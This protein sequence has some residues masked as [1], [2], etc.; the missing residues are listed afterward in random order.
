[1]ARCGHPIIPHYPLFLLL[2]PYTLL[3]A[4]A[5][6]YTRPSQVGLHRTRR[7]ILLAATNLAYAPLARN[8]LRTAARACLSERIEL[9]AADA[10]TRALLLADAAATSRYGDHCRGADN[11]VNNPPTITIVGP[12][13]NDGNGSS[14]SNGDQGNAGPEDA[15]RPQPPPPPTAATTEGLP[16][17]SSGFNRLTAVRARRILR[18]LRAGVDVLYSDVDI[19][20][21]RDPFTALPLLRA[22]AAAA[23][24]AGAA[25][26]AGE[27]GAA[28][29]SSSPDPSWDIAVAVDERPRGDARARTDAFP[30]DP[31]PALPVSLHSPV[32]PVACTGF[33]YVRSTP[34]SIDLMRRWWDATRTGEE[35]DQTA[36]NRLLHGHVHAAPSRASS[37][38]AAAVAAAA[39]SGVASPGA[40]SRGDGARGDGA[41][42]PEKPEK[43]QPSIPNANPNANSITDPNTYPNTYPNTDT[44]TDR[45]VRVRYLEE[46]VVVNG[47]TFFEQWWAQSDRMATV[48]AV[49]NNHIKGLDEKIR[50][51]RDQGLWL[52][53]GAG[54]VMG[55]G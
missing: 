45:K 8:F 46:D 39:L 35:Q 1:M 37:S 55:D 44:N 17:N 9:H 27:A 15:P 19:A 10:A 36:F 31:F 43:R 11:D 54:G 42:E 14:G 26:E 23:G 41:G 52:L 22:A 29:A 33:M 50:R 21:L 30:A 12:E 7:P 48:T 3:H 51:F 6:P 16:F 25:G 24:A 40:A 5:P 2:L 49:H 13:S 34:R 32:L 53:E 4:I 47:Y 38:A 20:L 28:G 18:H